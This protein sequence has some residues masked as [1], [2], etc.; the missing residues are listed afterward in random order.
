MTN[1]L[2]ISFRLKGPMNGRLPN[3]A[4]ILPAEECLLR[5]SQIMCLFPKHHQ[6]RTIE[7]GWTID[8]F[9][10]DWDKVEKA[11]RRAFLGQK[12]EAKG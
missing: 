7:N 4:K 12:V 3:P 2:M 6:I 8:V 10:D 9:P 1:D 5:L 11:F